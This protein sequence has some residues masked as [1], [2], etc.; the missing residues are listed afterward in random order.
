[1]KVNAQARTPASGAAPE[2]TPPDVD[3]RL[4]G[5][6]NPPRPTGPSRFA[7]LPSV[8]RAATGAAVTMCLVVSVV[9]MFMVFLFV[10]PPN[11][12]SQR[13]ANQV[14]AWIYPFFEQNWRLFAPDPESNVPQIEARTSD[15]FPDSAPGAGT[16]A[17]HFSGWF[18]LTALDDA[19]VRHDPFPSHTAQNM[20]RRAWTGYLDVNGTADHPRSGRALMMQQYLRNIALER[21]A[22]HRHGAVAAV[23]LRVRTRPV[24]P[25]TPPGTPR[26]T[27]PTAVETRI[28]PWWKVEP[29]AH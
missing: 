29:R 16:R 1:M 11:Q 28:L 7:G 22:P 8:L 12:I 24:P 3:R 18:D 4:P 14:N 17:P 10:A 2:N 5:E 21:L 25:P 6:K 19:S 23:Q 9:H 26:R 13:Y 27:G 15:V 20:L